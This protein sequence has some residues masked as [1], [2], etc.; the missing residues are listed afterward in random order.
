[1]IDVSVWKNFVSFFLKKK[2]FVYNIYLF[3][4]HIIGKDIEI[5]KKILK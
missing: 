4:K 5:A 2:L 3:S 1:M